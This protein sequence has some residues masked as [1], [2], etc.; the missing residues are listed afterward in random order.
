KSGLLKMYAAT[1]SSSTSLAASADN[2][3]VSNAMSSE[4]EQCKQ[5]LEQAQQYMQNQNYK[6]S[7]DLVEQVLRI[8]PNDIAALTLKGQLLGTAGR[9]A[10][11]IAT[12][13]QIL[14][15][16]PN[17]AL[18]WSMRAVLLSNMG[19]HQSALSA[20]ERSLEIDANNPESYGIKTR[21]M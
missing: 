13:E 6:A 12:V 16:D 15:S 2:G 17:N 4:Q 10:E 18:A 8:A 3:P 20:I 7:F 14:Q 1:A 11:G 9:W 5:M 19:E 21:I